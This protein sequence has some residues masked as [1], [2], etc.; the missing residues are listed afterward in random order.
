MSQKNRLDLYE[1]FKNGD[2]PDQEDFADTID[3]ALNLVDD[4]LVSYKVVTPT[5]GTLKRFGI[6]GETAPE[7]PL[8]IKGEKGQEDEMICFKSAD[9]SQKWNINLNPTGKIAT[10]FS[11]DDASKGISNSR[12]FIDQVSEGNVGIG[13]VEPEQKLHVQGAHDGGNISIMIEN[14]ESGEDGGW[15][16]SAIEDNVIPERRNVF[17]IQEKFGTELL[18]RM[19]FLTDSGSTSTARAAIAPGP[20]PLP[21]NPI[22]NVGINEILPYAPL[23][24]SQ[25]NSDPRSRVNMAE[26]TGIL[27]LG[28][29]EGPNLVLDSNQ[30][31]A[32]TGEYLSDGVTLRFTPSELQIQPFGGNVIVNGTLPATEQVEISSDGKIGI[33][34]TATEKVDINGAVTIG[35]TDTAVPSDGTVRFGGPDADLEVWKDAQWNSLTTHTVTDGLWV[36]GGGGVI[37]YDG[38]A[39]GNPKV[40]IGLTAPNAALHVREENPSATGNS[41]AMIVN[42]LS[43]TSSLDPSMTRVGLGVTCSGLWSSASAALN[44]GIYV[45]NVVGQTAPESNIAAAFNGNTVIGGVTGNSLIGAGGTNVL[46]IQTGTEPTSIPGITPNSGI[47]IY[48]TDLGGG[49]GVIPTSIFNVMTGDGEVIKLYRQENMTAADV[50]V[51]N[52]GN[53]VSDAL[54]ENMRTRINELEAMLKLLGLLAP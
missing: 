38:T 44:I 46:A 5:F 14:L 28:P 48:S 15:L 4:G 30:I 33:G 50:N 10:G 34:K 54:I 18:E 49:V 9:E 7:C 31:Q 16:M 36:N 1:E 12:L 39:A 29:V 22:R 13:T 41:G 53:A 8:G 24:V 23:H 42:N 52:T 51:P 32:R 6:G 43:G 45:S 40:G 47:Q 3:S 17:A 19:T 27:M 21:V 20:A 25:P 35:D 11:I 26:N 37:Y 2:I